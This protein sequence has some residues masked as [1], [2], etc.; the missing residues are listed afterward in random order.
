MPDFT[1]LD[2]NKIEKLISAFNRGIDNFINNLEGIK[3]IHR[4]SITT[5]EVLEDLLAL[6]R[7]ETT[8]EKIK[9]LHS[10]KSSIIKEKSEISFEDLLIIERPTREGSISCYIEEVMRMEEIPP[11]LLLSEDLSPEEILMHLPPLREEEKAEKYSPLQYFARDKISAFEGA[12]MRK[13]RMMTFEIY[14]EKP[15]IDELELKTLKGLYTSDPIYTLRHIK[16]GGGF[17][18]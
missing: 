1:N 14:A 5:K 6:S 2:D 7:K 9:S 12:E 15:H 18:D 4:V 17:Y 13:K 8:L 11:R 10:Q 3:K 16:E